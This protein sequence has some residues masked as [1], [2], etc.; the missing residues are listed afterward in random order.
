MSTE[1]SISLIRQKLESSSGKDFWKGL[2]ELGETEE[3]TEFLEKE[4]PRQAAPLASAVDRRDILK[5]LGASLAFAGLSACARPGA[6]SEKIVPYVKAPEEMIPG[7]PLFFSTAINNGGYAEGILVESHQ[8]RP[9]KI[10][11]N[12]DH[13]A[14]LGATSARTQAT[15]LTVY[16]PDRSQFISETGDQR[17]WAEFT[18]ALETALRTL[19]NGVGLAIL[20]ET[21]TS[22]SL[23]SLLN[24]VISRYPGAAWYQYDPTHDDAATKAAEASFGQAVSI[25]HDFSKADVIL[26]FDFDFTNEG[27]GNLRYAKDFSR[28]RR[29]RQAGEEMNRLYQLESFPSPTGAL[30]DNRI[31]L[32]AS[33][34]AAFAANVARGLGIDAPDVPLPSD[35]ESYLEAVLEDLRSNKGNSLVL[36][37]PNQ[38]PD[39]H[40]LTHSINEVLGNIGNTVTIH[41]PVEVNPVDQTASL[42]ALSDRLSNGEVQVL[43]VLGGNPAYNA[44]VGLGLKESIKAVP[45]SLHLGDYRDETGVLTTWHVNRA[46]YLEAWADSRA[47]DGTVTIQQPLISP[48]YGG[49]SDLE[50]LAAALGKPNATPYE[51]VQDHWKQQVSGDFDAFWRSALHSGTLEGTSA[52]RLDLK[53]NLL[54][55]HFPESSGLRI[56]VRPDP[57]IWAGRHSNNGWLQELPKPFNKITW[58]N[59]AYLS[60]RTAEELGVRSHQLLN[61]SVGERT[62][63]VPAWVQPGQAKDTVVLTMGYGRQEAGRIGNNIGVDAFSLLNGDENFDAP[64]QIE[65]AKGKARLA[66]TQVHQNLNGTGE[67]RHIIRSGTIGELNEHPDHVPFVHPVEHHTED[68]YPDYEYN[69]YAWGMVIDMTVCNGCNACITACQS[70]NNIPIVGKEQVLI[71]REL[72]WIRVDNYYRGDIDDPEIHHQPMP[73][74]QCEKAPCEPV[75]PVGATVHDHEGLNVMVYN[76]CVG[77]RYCS[78]NCPYKVRRFNFLQY[79]E[80]DTTS[81]ELSLA[82]N[83]DVTVRSRGVMEKC[84]YCTQRISQAR[85]PADNEDRKILD[86][87]IITACQGACP[88]EA[89]V[90]GDIN[91]ATSDVSIAKTSPLNYTMLEEL[92]TKPRTSYLAKVTNP[93]PLLAPKQSGS[94]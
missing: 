47:Y 50:I 4:F 58:E 27:P 33:E 34:L 53:P 9:T 84:T 71:G 31:P 62:V 49:R 15:V 39:L 26:S 72:H 43:L 35:T 20:T 74:Q 8:G 14:S 3:F 44:P 22:P 70:E 83:P 18:E 37:G 32:N 88:M 10:E 57:T 78:N 85:I 55:V 93:H 17:T 60:P 87:E 12:P 82:N 76:R 66:S 5:I 73:C 7:Q 1:P 21:V 40:V 77:T 54:E 48:F 38:S 6:P 23:S 45:F 2:D 30:A 29:I 61:L 92:Q 80:L 41:E 19:D 52:K 81:T 67:R 51:T 69:G 11:G 91:D 75:C 86:G 59:A 63:T 68:L 64:V 36:A 16:D 28:K 94:H 42:N 56:L 46:H 25:Q 65:F 13:P 89:I 90:F 24:Q 79:A